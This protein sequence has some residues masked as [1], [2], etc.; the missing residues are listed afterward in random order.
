[1][2]ETSLAHSASKAGLGT[3]ASRILGYIRDMLIASYFG[4]G[5]SADA[6]YVAFR[7]PNLLRN[8]L[9]EG[10]LSAS[11]IPVFSQYLV[12][13][14]EDAWEI[15]RITFSILLVLLS[16]L[17]LLGIAITPF[18]VRIIAPGFISLPD[19]FSLT[20]TL[21]R[22][23][24]PFFL[25]ICL[26]A[27]ATG[28]LNSLRSFFV[29]A[30][31]PSML[32]LG[33][34]FSVIVLVP[35]MGGSVK[36]LAC[37]VLLGGLG[38]LLA[39]VPSVIKFWPRRGTRTHFV[40]TRQSVGTPGWSGYFKFVFSHPG[41]KKI[42]ILMLPATLGLGVFQINAFVDTI[43]AS[44]LIEGSPTALYYANR[45]M[46]LPLAIF[47]TSVATVSLPTMS[48]FMANKDKEGL[49]KTLSTS[50][51]MIFFLLMPASI[52]LIIL[53]KP[54]VALL[55]QRGRFDVF[56]TNLTT[57]ALLFYSMGLISYGG[58]KVVASAFYSMQDTKTPLQVSIIAMLLNVELNFIFMRFMGVGG[59][60]LATAISS[61][62]NVSLLLFLLRR[63][64]GKLQGGETLNF[65]WRMGVI[66]GVI[67]IICFI[68]LKLGLN[69]FFQV[70]LGIGLSI[71]VLFSLGF[72][73]RFK[74]A[75][76]L[77]GQ[78]AQIKRFT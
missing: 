64:I 61:T 37:G 26:A 20:V 59:L 1:M 41:V 57:Q 45:L 48:A 19:K 13:K 68:L 73:F 3:L 25:L 7:I 2:K 29:P 18:I 24:F 35:L 76:E 62:V 47:A 56:A 5:T 65:F 11:F 40:G 21:T 46:Q 44:Y 67:G 55:F 43:C 58:V 33:E 50:V 78:I 14:E 34:I 22:I 10:A 75:R 23:M 15:A 77:W 30:V 51:K 6:F 28:I 52:G 70:I 69:V 53:G 8:L 38:Q 63:R 4:A 42:G 9:G 54:I 71:V 31:A 17:T 32:S 60:A 49:L 72:L 74:E 36:G 66:S 27:L 12:K 39:Q 16:L